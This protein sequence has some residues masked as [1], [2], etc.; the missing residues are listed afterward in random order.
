MNIRENIK[1]G[2]K[3]IKANKLRTFLTAALISIGITSLV[4]I[5]TAIDGIQNSIDK[6]FS[7]LGANTF[8]IEDKRRGR[9]SSDGKKE[10][11]YPKVTYDQ[12]LTFKEKY[13]GPGTPS[14]YTVITGQAEVKYGS[15]VTNPNQ[16]VR[17]GDENYLTV[18]GYD[19]AEGRPFSANESLNGSYVALVGS[20]VIDELFDDNVSPVGKKISLMGSKFRI[21][22]T[23]AEQGGASGT[24][25]IDRTIIIPMQTARIIAP[26]RNFGYEI[27]VSV[28]DPTQMENAMAIAR[29][30]MRK[31]R[32]DRPGQEDSF[33]LSASKSLAQRIGSITGNLRIGGFVVG[34]LTLLGASIG[35][36]N[37]MMVS[38]TERTREIGVRKALGATPLKI[39]QQFLIEAIVITQM[40]GIG[41]IIFGMGIGNLT[42]TVLFKSDFI[43]P[44]LWMFVA[45]VIGIVVGLISGYIPAHK[46]SKLDPIDSLRF[47]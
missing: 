13:E 17:G 43:V 10:K 36:M 1:E 29:G 47:E 3:S 32:R 25:N 28:A 44:W 6:S 45:V 33:E 9:G 34:F 2:I 8:D 16:I 35:L 11:S 22:G 4:G 31:I 21:V 30:L 40:G 39:R 46:A 18:D 24:S 42:S 20:D 12:L 19:V 27:A 38:V 23:I 5:L 15:K 26:E 37:I 7:S 14:I 41:G